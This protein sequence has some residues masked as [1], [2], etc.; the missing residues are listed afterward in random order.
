MR[1]WLPAVP[2]LVVVAITA[3]TYTSLP[4]T[5]RLDWQRL[6]PIGAVDGEPIGRPMFAAITPVLAILVWIGMSALAGVRG[7]K[8]GRLP[9]RIAADAIARF[10][11]TY[12]VVVT[13][14]VALIVLI[15]LAFLALA[16]QWDDWTLKAIGLTM[17]LGMFAV[18]NLMPRVRP[19]W[20]VGIRTR[21][22]LSD[23]ALWMRAHRY[24]GALLM[25]SGLI[26]AGVA[27]VAVRFALVTLIVALLVSL[28]L[29][30]WM[31]TA[32]APPRHPSSTSGPMTKV[33]LPN[34]S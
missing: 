15:Q 33:E 2:I 31:A 10:E 9:E 21:A 25:A 13:A 30:H 6:F 1:K 22:T 32:S 12:H 20:I 5:V 17:G 18:G 27:L 16:L 29:A 8:D 3:L 23:P 19:N 4:E 26:A 14:V 34:G 24:L 7:S 28:V 11:P